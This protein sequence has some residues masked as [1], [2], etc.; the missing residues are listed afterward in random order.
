M[1]QPVVIPKKYEANKHIYYELAARFRLRHRIDLNAHVA[2]ISSVQPRLE[3]GVFFE[4]VDAKAWEEALKKARFQHD[5]HESHLGFIPSIGKIASLATHGKGYRERGSPSLHC[6]IAP[7]VCNV[8]L[9]K[10]GIRA[11]NYGPNAGVHTADELGWQTFVVPALGKILPSEVADL[12]YRIHPIVPNT[13]Q[14]KPLSMVGVALEIASGRS[15]DLQQSWQ[16]TIDLTHACADATCGGW[17][18]VHGQSVKGENNLMIM[19]KVGGM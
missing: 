5:L 11:D 15:R 4:P 9:D 17:R 12:F 1:S 14:F 6:A 18:T 7:D 10:I 16:V 13:Q 2:S 8:H 3:Q 19:F